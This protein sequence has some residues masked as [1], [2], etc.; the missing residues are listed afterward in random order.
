M[1]VKFNLKMLPTI[2]YLKG[3]SYAKLYCKKLSNQKPTGTLGNRVQLQ[4]DIEN[5]LM[6]VCF[7][8]PPLQNVP[9]LYLIL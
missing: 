8:G 4:N 5:C 1:L 3:Y 7:Y 2:S 6:S 9:I